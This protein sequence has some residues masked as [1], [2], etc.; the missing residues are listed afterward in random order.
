[1]PGDFLNI[2]QTKLMN[3]S[4]VE[5]NIVVVIMWALA[6]NNQRAKIILKSA[7]HDSTLQNTIKHCQ[8]LSGLESKLSNED[9]DRM[10]YVLNLLRD[11]DKIR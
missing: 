11:N 7:H 5:K 1:M 6:A 9:L 2:L 4:N 10:Y 8:L 3:G